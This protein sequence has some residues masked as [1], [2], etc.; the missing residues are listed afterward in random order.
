MPRDQ[1][2]DLIQAT[3]AGDSE[4]FGTLVERYERPL[5]NAALRIT[6]NREDAMDATQNAFVNAYE[7]LGRFDFRFRFFSWIYRITI[8]EALDL[9]RPAQKST[10]LP[11]EL[12]A[13]NPSPLERA[14]ETE[15]SRLVQRAL[16]ELSEQDRVVIVLRHFLELT[17]DEMAEI[18]DIHAKTVKSRLFSARQRIRTV[19]A[20]MGL[21]VPR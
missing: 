15:S 12:P 20:G 3:L 6:G 5:F 9:V 1:D 8:N 14:G 7:N 18:L 21:G 11:E 10:E 13:A 2:A 19:L 4:A 17:Y 16:L